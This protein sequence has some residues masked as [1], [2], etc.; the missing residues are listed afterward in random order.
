M[1][2]M[3][4]TVSTALKLLWPLVFGMVV[5][6]FSASAAA[7]QSDKIV[8]GALR[9]TS[10]GPIF[11]ALDRGYFRD[12]GL[13]VEMAFFQDAPTVA[14]ATASGDVS[15]GVTALT[16][17]F[18]NLAS[19]GDLKILAG[20]AQEKQG[21][22]GNLILVTKKAFD[23][24]H[25]RLDKLFDQ[26]FGLT[27]RGSPSHYQLGQLAGAEGV[28]LDGLNIQAFQTL[29]NLVAALKSA[30]ITWAIIAPPIASDL[31]ESGAVV[32]L[33]PYSDHGSYQFGGV[34]ASADTIAADPDLVRR[35]LRA[36]K[37]GLGD[38]SQ[39]VLSPG[40]D[41]ARRAATVVA[42]YVY[43]DLPPEKA[44][45]KVLGSALY[46]DPT[47]QVDVADIER[48]IAWYHANDMVKTVPEIGSILRLDLLE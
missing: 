21:Y 31:I 28:P 10:S 34:F 48:Q 7:A 40:S 39:I 29:P 22:S 27:Q 3:G 32:S 4:S 35:F 42:G 45:A 41:Q 37:K 44:A 2:A 38:Y 26:P 13:T 33:G 11:L 25:D 5:A 15:F 12:E 20:Q 46:V 36:Y 16:A 1:T 30:Q 8:V 43:P 9:F 23:A 24:G 14:A 19:Q 47:G 17:A 18:F 6:I